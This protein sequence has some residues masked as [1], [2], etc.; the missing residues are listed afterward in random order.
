MSTISIKFNEV[1][2]LAP[3]NNV[4]LCDNNSF[5]YSCDARFDFSLLF[6]QSILSIGP[7]AILLLVAP[8]RILQLSQSSYKVRKHPSKWSKIVSSS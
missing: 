1:G 5:L 3:R 4:T 7:S 8:L 2:Y 6:E